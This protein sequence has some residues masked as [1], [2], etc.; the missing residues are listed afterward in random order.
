[1]EWTASDDRMRP[2]SRPM[3]VV[4]MVVATWLAPGHAAAGHGPVHTPCAEGNFSS[5]ANTS[6]DTYSESGASFNCASCPPGATSM[7]MAGSADIS[8]CE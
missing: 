2:V 4:V 5:A 8:R 7:M 1:M 6:R 3:V